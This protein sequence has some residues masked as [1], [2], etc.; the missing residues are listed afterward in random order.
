MRP[1]CLP[2][3]SSANDVRWK[4]GMATGSQQARSSFPC[5]LKCVDSDFPLV[6]YPIQ[7]P[8][9]VQPCTASMAAGGEAS[10]QRTPEVG[11][12]T[13]HRHCMPERFWVYSERLGLSWRHG[14]LCVQEGL[15]ERHK[16]A[17]IDRG[18]AGLCTGATLQ[19][20]I[21]RGHPPWSY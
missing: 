11:V 7:R 2:L 1:A 21:C 4:T 6:G 10:F 15:L 17:G 13:K 18:M 12:R 14:L 3:W 5:E 20:Q 8:M 19:V 9:G 16:S